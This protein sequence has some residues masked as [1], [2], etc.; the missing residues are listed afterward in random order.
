MRLA[1]IAIVLAACHHGHAT[2]S[3]PP[4]VADSEALLGHGASLVFGEIHGTQQIPA[5]IGAMTC[6]AAATH[7]V[8]VGLEIWRTEQ[9]R[10]DAYL[11]SDGGPAARKELLAGGFWTRATQDG[12]SSEAMAGL[13]EHLRAWR[14]AGAHLELVAFDVG[15]AG[16]QSASDQAARERAMSEPLLAARRANADATMIVLVGNLHARMTGGVS[17]APDVTWMAQYL[18]RAIPN[19]A[20]FDAAYGRGTAW[21]CDQ[22]SCGERPWG[23]GDDAGPTRITQDPVLDKSYSGHL[24]VGAIA[25]GKPAT[26]Q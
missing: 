23:R 1:A 26:S 8:V 7:D 16:E 20:T 15:E 11:A 18:A 13:I 22:T 10:L 21:V 24:H 25:A 19:L 4:A 5:A 17:F 3:C 2:L 14:A 12:R 9:A 6:A